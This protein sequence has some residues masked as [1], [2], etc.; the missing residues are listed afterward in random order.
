MIPSYLLPQN[1]FYWAIAT[2]VISGLFVIATLLR[3]VLMHSGIGNV[4]IFKITLMEYFFIT[5]QL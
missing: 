5:Y 3:M 1:V 2:L 4:I